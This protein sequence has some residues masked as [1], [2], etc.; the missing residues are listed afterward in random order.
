[1]YGG[2]YDEAFLG[3]SLGKSLP[4]SWRQQDLGDLAVVC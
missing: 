3:I 4:G 2:V 1:M